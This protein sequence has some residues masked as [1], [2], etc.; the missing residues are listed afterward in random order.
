[1]AKNMDKD[2]TLRQ[3]TDLLR[4]ALSGAIEISPKARQINRSR[5]DDPRRRDSERL[6]RR[7][8]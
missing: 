8:W 2:L 6:L 4:I 5:T 1:M 3:R 7:Q